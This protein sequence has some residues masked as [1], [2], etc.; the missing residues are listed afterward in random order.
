MKVAKNGLSAELLDQL[1]NFYNTIFLYDKNNERITLR[2]YEDAHYIEVISNNG[3]YYPKL[4][5]K[6]GVVLDFD[7]F[8]KKLKDRVKAR[9]FIKQVSENIRKR[10]TNIFRYTS[11]G[12]TTNKEVSNEMLEEVKQELNGY[13]YELVFDRDKKLKEILMLPN[14]HNKNEL[15]KRL[16]KL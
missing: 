8:R 14:R 16:Q 9:L 10:F 7:K 3:F 5:L 13:I 12:I 1:L 6:E 2:E 11:Y 15:E 4:K